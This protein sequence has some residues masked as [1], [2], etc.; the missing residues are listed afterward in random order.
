MGHLGY[1]SRHTQVPYDYTDCLPH[2]DQ[3]IIEH[4]GQTYWVHV[5]C[6]IDLRRNRRQAFELTKR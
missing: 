6:C 1:S 3:L 2:Y 5:S 4:S